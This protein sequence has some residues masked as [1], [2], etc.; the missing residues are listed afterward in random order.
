MTSVSD[1][2][3]E[4][5]HLEGTEPQRRDAE[6]AGFFRQR[7]GLAQHLRYDPTR[8]GVLSAP[9][10]FSMGPAA[11]DHVGT[12]LAG[13][14]TVARTELGEAA[15]ESSV[16]TADLRGI[17]DQPLEA[18][19]LIPILRRAASGILTVDDSRQE[20]IHQLLTSNGVRVPFRGNAPNDG[21]DL[22]AGLLLTEPPGYGWS[23]L[24]PPSESFD[25]VAFVI[26]YNEE[27]I[28]EAAL[29][30]LVDQGV[31]VYVIDNWS[32][33]R[34]YEIAHSL[35]GR[36][37]VGLERYPQGGPPKYFDLRSLLERIEV[38]AG[39]LGADWYMKHDADEFRRSPWPD[40]SLR[41]G[42]YAVQCAGFNCVDFTVLNF[43]PVDDGFEAGMDPLGYFRYFDF[44]RKPGHFR[45][46][47]AW[48]NTGEPIEY[49]SLGSHRI[50]FP[51]L[52]IFPYKFLLR[53]YPVRSQRH[54]ERK[55]FAERQS[56]FLPE[57][58]KRGW[59][60]HYDAIEA[61]HSFIRNSGDLREWD[62]VDFGRRYLVERLSGIGVE[63]ED[64]GAARGSNP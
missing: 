18:E 55:V 13:G 34:S 31:S 8:E 33:D 39:E 32:S 16:V 53:H 52:R 10:V 5:L 3:H 37:V 59:H 60:R 4:D 6:L 29:S 19:R 27:D 48:R 41:D 14:A 7:S 28:L 42:F 49:A 57:A 36:G 51:G 2:A 26:V 56:R 61:G 47:K 62:E 25:V 40:V 45:Q 15:V 12:R 9:G 50:R 1:V 43:E 21:S 24:R 22:G 44:G 11:L 38:L 64:A 46:L 63:R 58:R 23:A 30:D 35:R 54:G 17:R 20:L